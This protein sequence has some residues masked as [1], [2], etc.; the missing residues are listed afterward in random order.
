MGQRRNGSGGGG[1]AVDESAI[2]VA[3][4]LMPVAKTELPR[5]AHEYFHLE[6]DR[7]I[8]TRIIEFMRPLYEQARMDEQRSI[9][10]V[11]V[12]DPAVPPVRKAFPRRSIICIV[13][14][15]SAFMLAIA[16]V[17]AQAWWRRNHA[18][19]AHRLD[20]AATQEKVST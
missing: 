17:L 12:V 5:V 19:L 20:K 4:E 18:Y 6:K 15:L 11:Q 14:T 7:R 9:Q 2:T 8:L 16:F 10:A 13:A 1:D 3:E